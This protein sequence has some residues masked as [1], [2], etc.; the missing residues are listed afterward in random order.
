MRRLVAEYV[1]EDMLPLSTVDSPSFT[2]IVNKTPILIYRGTWVMS[3]N[4]ACLIT[5]RG[6]ELL[7][8]LSRVLIETKVLT[9]KM[10]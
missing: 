1:V 7:E 6:H 5:S 3:M 10:F 4:H 8:M 9:Y 2:K